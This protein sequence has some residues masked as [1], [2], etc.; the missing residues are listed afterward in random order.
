MVRF[1]RF[2][3]ALAVISVVVSFLSVAACLAADSNDFDFAHP[4]SHRIYL[5]E[6]TIGTSTGP[7]PIW[8]DG[9]MRAMVTNPNG[10][11][12]EYVNDRAP[13]G[14]RRWLW[15]HRY[16][17]HLVRGLKPG[18]NLVRTRFF[19]MNSDQPVDEKVI[20]ITYDPSLRPRRGQPVLVAANESG[21]VLIALSDRLPLA[22][23]D[24]PNLLV[25]NDLARA[26]AYDP[27]QNAMVS[28]DLLAMSVGSRLRNTPLYRRP[29]RLLANGQLVQLDDGDLYDLATEQLLDLPDNYAAISENGR[30]IVWEVATGY[31]ILDRADGATK[32]CKVST[33]DFLSVNVSD[34]GEVALASYSWATGNLK[35]LRDCQVIVEEDSM[36][37]LL[38]DCVFLGSAAG[39]AS[40]LAVAGG[41]ANYLYE[42]ESEKL[43]RVDL[44][45]GQVDL[46]RNWPAS[47]IRLTPGGS[48]LVATSKP[49]PYS[50]SFYYRAALYNS[51]LSKI[52]PEIVVPDVVTAWSV[53]GV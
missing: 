22:V 7:L 25:H 17:Y 19:K 53:S 27:R 32:T 38:G 18:K 23:L 42:R 1:R 4:G 51:A 10:S 48:L 31:A 3:S 37:D 46:T 52:I 16:F 12:T 8:L 34:F 47:T 14:G 45:S 44:Q 49:Q 28:V 40:T 5:R 9:G 30:Y 13:A 26:V 41:D 33:R 39:S 2:I 6:Y 43:I 36:I 21:S 15:N 29:R 35:I 50:Y 20:T 11:S 24:L